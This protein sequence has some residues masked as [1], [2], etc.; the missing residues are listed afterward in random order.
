MFKVIVSWHEYTHEDWRSEE[1]EG[2]SLDDACLYAA[3]LLETPTA[4]ALPGYTV[5]VVEVGV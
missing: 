3:W 1:E 5:T 2:S 4:R